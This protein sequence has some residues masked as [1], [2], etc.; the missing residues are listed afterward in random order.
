MIASIMIGIALVI[1]QVERF[2][3]RI[4]PIYDHVALV[5]LST[6]PFGFRLK[7]LLRSYKYF[8][9]IKISTKY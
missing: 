4:Q 1:G 2:L 6:D 8:D 5:R 3:T 9:C 7:S